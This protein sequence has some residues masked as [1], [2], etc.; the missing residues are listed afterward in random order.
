MTT[1]FDLQQVF[2]SHWSKE[3]CYAARCQGYFD[4]P[5]QEPKVQVELNVNYKG[6]DYTIL[7]EAHTVRYVKHKSCSPIQDAPG[8]S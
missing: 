2:C 5:L 8:S 6:Q 3:E 4:W 1:T 7:L